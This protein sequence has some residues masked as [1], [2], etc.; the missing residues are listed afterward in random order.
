MRNINL[1]YTLLF[2]MCVLSTGTAYYMGR[3][4]SQKGSS[5]EIL[6]ADN[7]EVSS[8]LND[9]DSDNV[10]PELPSSGLD[11]KKELYSTQKLIGDLKVGSYYEADLETER[12]M[13]LIIGK[14]YIDNEDLENFS[15]EALQEIDD[16]WKNYT[17]GVFSF[18]VLRDI[19]VKADIHNQGYQLQIATNSSGENLPFSDEPHTALFKHHLYAVRGEKMKQRQAPNFISA[20]EPKNVSGARENFL[21]LNSRLASCGLVEDREVMRKAWVDRY[22]VEDYQQRVEDYQSSQDLLGLMS[23]KPHPWY[24]EFYGKHE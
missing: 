6:N 13:M 9:E 11:E 10:T 24:T 19:F 4:Q 12:L 3:F 8:A 17:G 22:V 15:C 23:P 7:L 18:S 14:D 1:R 21:S 2:L 5:S 20:I 16:I